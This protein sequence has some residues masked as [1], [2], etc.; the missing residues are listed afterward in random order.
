QS[1]WSPYLRREVSFERPGGAAGMQARTRII[2][3]TAAALLAATASVVTS[4]ISHAG[5]RTA[6]G[7]DWATVQSILSGIQG[8]ASAPI[9]NVVNPKYT[10]GMLLGNG[11]LGVVAGGDRTTNQR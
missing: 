9:A 2:A 4:T 10:A 3:A 8:R 1:R 7:D 5:V 6:A 11:D